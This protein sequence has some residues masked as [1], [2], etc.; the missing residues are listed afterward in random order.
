MC[1]RIV[2]YKTVLILQNLVGTPSC[3]KSVLIYVISYNVDCNCFVMLMFYPEFVSFF[4]I[5]GSRCALRKSAQMKDR[6][7][8]MVV[9]A[10]SNER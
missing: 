1:L 10:S 2:N 6:F 9:L 5:R 8:E 4:N 3:A 7:Y